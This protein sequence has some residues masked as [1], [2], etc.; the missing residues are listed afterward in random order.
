V[1]G[2]YHSFLINDR[3]CVKIR[4]KQTIL[5]ILIQVLFAAGLQ[6]CIRPWSNTEPWVAPTIEPVYTDE[7]P[8][9]T[10]LPFLP[11]TREPNTPILSPTPD[12]PHAIPT[13]RSK[14]EEYTIRP[15]DT[16]G[17]IAQRFGV[18]IQK[19]IILNKLENPDRVEVGQV[20]QIPPPDP[21]AA[22]PGFKII[23]DSE[24][25]YG[26]ASAVFDISGFLTQQGGYLSR[27][28]EEIDKQSYTGAEI[29][30]R[31]AHD[32]SVNPRLLLAVL[33]YKSGWVTRPY[34]DKD[35]YIYPMGLNNEWKQGLYLQLAWAANNLNRGFYLWKANAV[36]NW[37][38]VDG[39][40]VAVSPDI[41]A[42]TAGVQ[43][44]MS[45]LF[46]RKDWDYAISENGVF[47]T[48]SELFGFPFDQAIEPLI[49]GDLQQPVFQLPFGPG[50]EWSFTGGPHGGYGDG[51]AWAGIDFAPPGDALGCVQSDVWVQAVAD[52]TVVRTGNG[53]VIQD[54]DGDGYE[55]TGWTI[56]YLH[57]ETRDRVETGTKLK[58]GDPIGHPSCEGGVSNGTHVH[59]ARRYN[60]EWI[61]ADGS[62]PFNL[63]GW[64]SS[65]D[66]TE[67]N[68][69]LRR[70]GQVVEAWDS[71]KPEN[72]I[73]R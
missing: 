44:L 3:I 32:F 43:Q 45:L 40:V 39:S 46:G 29:V 55:Q 15:N 28:S 41:N 67:Y 54:L 13:L 2:D 25:V 34:P 31:V 6:G 62:I 37:V 49:P 16:L 12:T 42:G 8:T 48:Y 69:F 58:A 14:M 64:I 11:P 66:G 63:D 7:P 26:P 52:G 18:D 21:Q 72:Q 38:L 56:L 4:T 22:G 23:P 10:P 35:T 61:S 19:L 17:L 53:Q 73:K 57:I 33:E 30:S 36:P 5:L 20:I 47:K 51:S 50:E 70:D 59:L 1:D 68:G 71:R 24:L 27:H 60:G 9:A 65:G